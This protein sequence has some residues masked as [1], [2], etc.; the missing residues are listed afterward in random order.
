VHAQAVAHVYPPVSTFRFSAPGTV[1]VAR[2][3]LQVTHPTDPYISTSTYTNACARAT[4][5]QCCVHCIG[6]QVCLCELVCT[7]KGI[8]K[9]ALGRW[10][11]VTIK[12]R[13]W[14]LNCI[15]CT[16]VIQ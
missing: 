9:K 13:L 15:Y 3:W 8:R 11:A 12:I 5:G 1:S 4:T 2:P 6:K 7:C 16:F 14:L 10:M